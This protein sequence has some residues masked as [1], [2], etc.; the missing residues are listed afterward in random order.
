[1]GNWMAWK[2]KSRLFLGVFVNT[3]YIMGAISIIGPML[4][5]PDLVS[6]EYFS[7][8][9]FKLLWKKRWNLGKWSNDLWEFKMAFPF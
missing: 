6:N 3:E 4:G 1:M 7:N 5:K 9:Y 8:I 2:F